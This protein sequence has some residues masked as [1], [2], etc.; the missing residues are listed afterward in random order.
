[1]VTLGCEMPEIARQLSANE[2]PLQR[3]RCVRLVGKNWVKDFTNLYNS[4]DKFVNRDYAIINKLGELY[5]YQ[6]ATEVKFFLDHVDG[7]VRQEY[8]DTFLKTSNQDEQSTVKIRSPSTLLETLE[9]NVTLE[10]RW[11]GHTDIKQ[12]TNG[13]FRLYMK[14]NGNVHQVKFKR[15]PACVLYLIYL[16]DIYESRN[17]TTLDIANYG[18]RFCDLFY[19]VYAYGGQSQ[20]MNMIGQGTSSQKLLRHCLSDIREAVGNTCKLLH[21]EDL[22]YILLDKNSHL[23]VEKG[24]IDFD[25]KIFETKYGDLTRPYTY[26][27]AKKMQE[28]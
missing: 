7:K 13:R 19:K 26:D 28:V 9:S 4:T 12:P 20:F 14:K 18:N 8:F 24:N 2:N 10:V 16:L 22:P 11:I 15:R 5:D 17:T 25:Q 3:G 1:M 23:C 6:T 27:S 21:E